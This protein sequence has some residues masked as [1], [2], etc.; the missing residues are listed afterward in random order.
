[1]NVIIAAF[2]VLAAFA[3]DDL[4]F[5]GETVSLN[6]AGIVQTQPQQGPVNPEHFEAYFPAAESFDE[7]KAGNVLFDLSHYSYSAASYY[8]L[9]ISMLQSEGF[10]VTIAS[11][12]ANMMN[13][14]VVI[15]RNPS[16]GFSA[17]EVTLITNYLNAGNILIMM[18]EFWYSGTPYNNAYIN[19]LMDDLGAGINIVNEKI[20][21]PV[22]YYTHNF[23]IR[24]LDFSDHCLN[25]GVSEVIHAATS[26]IT[27]DNPDSALYRSSAQSYQSYSPYANGPFV[28]S[29]IPNPSTR[30]TWKLVLTGDTNLFSVSSSYNFYSMYDNAQ[31]AYNQVYWCSCDGNDDCDDGLYCNG[32]ETCNLGSGECE[33]G[34]APCP[35]D[36]LWCNGA[37]GCDEAGDQCTTTGDPCP[38]DGLFCTGTEDCDEAGDQCT[39]TGD[40]CGD[41]GL[42]C[43]GAES[44]DE[45]GD[46][47]ATTGNP[48]RDDVL[49]CNGTE[50][51]DEAADQCTNSGDPCPDDNLFCNGA[52]SCDEDEDQCATTGNPCPDDGLYCNGAETCDEDGDQC[53]TGD[54][55]CME[56]DLFCNGQESCN[57]EDDTCQS[58]GDPCA[59]QE[60]CNE[61]NDSCDS[62][63][64]DD[65]DPGLEDDDADD[66]DSD[67]DQWPQGNVTGG[68]DSGCCG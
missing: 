27:V 63:S 17:S 2:F 3:A 38:D 50:G 58:S 12:L 6:D 11:D 10:N 65:D 23:W 40:P 22:N 5:A 47:C 44:C 48:C 32:E 43:N 56:D 21:E 1:M 46:Q 59:Q 45:A 15:I 24:I 67:E 49:F 36:G 30:P 4:E 60:E 18:G 39:S 28:I 68:S 53:E 8:S 31:A 42:W 55:P 54:T 33:A 34:T 52:E 66:D 26:Y 13:Y 62:R 16:F 14:D 41:D 35:D 51:C 29:A 37:E 25:E 7:A 20:I 57:E 61:D 19:N 64:D 9:F